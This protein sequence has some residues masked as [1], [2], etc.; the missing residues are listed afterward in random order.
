MPDSA[1][2]QTGKRLFRSSLTVGAMTMISRVAG[3]VRDVV[4]ATMFGAA[5]NADAFYIAFRIPQFLR[6]LFAEGA[7]SQAFVP[8]LSE[9]RATRSV[10][11][12][13]VLVDAVSGVL[14]AALLSVTALIVIAAPVVT[15]VFAP[16]FLQMPEKM[17][18]TT[19]LIRITFPYLFLIS[20]TGFAGAVLNSYARFAVPAFTPV[21]LNLTLIAGAVLASPYFAEPTF[22]LAWAVLVAGLVQLV[23]QIPFIARIGMLPRPRLDIRHEGVRRILKLMLPALFGV[24]VSQINLL[25]DTVLASFLPTGS[26]SWLYFSE[27]LTE[28]PLGVF[29]IA[30]ATVILP[31]LSR[32]F[33]TR[34]AEE[35][36]HTLDWAIKMILMIGLPASFA[37]L[38]L[39]RP[40]LATLFQYGA[41]SGRDV[42]MASLSLSAMA[43]GL[44]AFMVIKVLASA[45]YSRQDMRTPVL[46]GIKAMVANMVLN[47]LFVVP[48][49]LLWQVGHAGLSLATTCSA[50]L[51]AGLLLSGLMRRDIYRPERGFLADIGRI[52]LATALMA[53]VLLLA[54][55]W[56][57]G[58][59]ELPWQQRA[60]RLTGVCGVGIAVYFGALLLQHPRFLQQ[61]RAR[62]GR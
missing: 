27:R 60:L 2:T 30:I 46:I 15:L 17:A 4:L 8:V 39:A 21:F 51:N 55:G 6:R 10:A 59:A 48:L 47:L 42:E 20:M 1:R 26:V 53:G 23:F 5:A 29:G 31:G 36:R 28:L 11:E 24:S 57:H 35:F 7:F 9:Y 12:V 37:L 16:G 32:E 45:Y 19:Q 62:S 54:G 25:L 43:L 58:L 34:S 56:L 38:I 14:G 61:A 49:H 13:K 18:L 22:A 3:L 50:Y 33:S 44:P 41:L 40:I 52:A